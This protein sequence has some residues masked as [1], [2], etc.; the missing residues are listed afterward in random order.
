MKSLPLQVQITDLLQDH[1]ILLPETVSKQLRIDRRST[2]RIRFGNAEDTVKVERMKHE[3][4]RIYISQDVATQLNI[5]FSQLAHLKRENNTLRLGPVVGFLI[6]G[7][8]IHRLESKMNSL[9]PSMNLNENYLFLFKAKDVD[10]E[11]KVVVGYFLSVGE[12]KKG[13]IEEHK[14]SFPDV[15][16]NCIPNRRLEKKIL[17]HFTKN[18][19][20]N[21]ACTFFNSSFFNKWKLHQLMAAHMETSS[22][23]PETKHATIPTIEDML[24]RYPTIVLKPTGGSLGRGIIKI[25]RLDE[26]HY[27]AQFYEKLHPVKINYQSFSQLVKEQLSQIDLT[28]YLV[29]QGILLIHSDGCPIDFRVHLNKAGSNKWHLSGLIAKVAGKNCVTTHVRTGGRVTDAE[30]A[31]EKWFK[32]D[33]HKILIELEEISIHIATIVELSLNQPIGELGLDL[34]IDQQGKVWLFEVNSKPGHIALRHAPS[35]KLHW[36]YRL[37]DYC[38]DLSGF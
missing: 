23:L 12:G 7:V 28:D 32:S 35:G 25:T 36:F 17:P 4:D 19:K 8:P 24:H 11:N 33:S 30:S 31:L 5:P 6:A 14:I 21:M 22:Y 37:M 34:G 3:F 10:W 9:I 18:I 26:Q 16:Y 13:R 2:M 38:H 15:I 1:V 20:Q 29:Q 27:T